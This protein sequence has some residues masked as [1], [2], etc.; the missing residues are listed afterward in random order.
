M[1]PVQPHAGRGHGEAVGRPPVLVAVERDD[2]ALRVPVAVAARHHGPDGL[3]VLAV[4]PGAHVEVLAVVSERHLRTFR[5][6]RALDRLPLHEVRAEGRRAPHLVVQPAVNLDRR[7]GR[8]PVGLHRLAHAAGALGPPARQQGRRLAGELIRDRVGAGDRR[9]IGNRVRRR[10]L[11]SGLGR[12]RDEHEEEGAGCR[13]AGPRQA[14]TVTPLVRNDWR[15]LSRSPCHP[16][17]P[18]LWVLRCS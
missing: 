2:Q 17:H 5:G 1:I 16:S 7:F 14:T 15:A 10:R 4:H 13:H 3:G 9:P 6:G 8:D 12:E 18:C 11:G